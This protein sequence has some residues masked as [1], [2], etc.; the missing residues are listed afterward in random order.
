MGMLHMSKTTVLSW[1]A[2]WL[3][4]FCLVYIYI[5]LYH[6]LRDDSVVKKY[7]KI[8]EELIDE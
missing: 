7:R 2:G 5:L 3:A 1:L 4:G 8:D 6:S